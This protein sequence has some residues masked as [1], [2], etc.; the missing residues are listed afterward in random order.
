MQLAQGKEG[1]HA[2]FEKLHEK[3]SLARQ[4]RE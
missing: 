3:F 2:Q 1:D 4:G